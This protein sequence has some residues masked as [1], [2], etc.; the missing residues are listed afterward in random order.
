MPRPR[1]V[2]VC[3]QCGSESP[4]WLGRC[5]EWN[6]YVESLVKPAPASRSGL[7]APVQELARLSSESLPRLVLP[8]IEFNRV[9]G[10]GVVPGSLV[11][12]GGDPG[13]G[14]STLL[15]QAAGAVASGDGTVLYVSGEESVHQIKLRADRLGLRG[16][17]LFL[18]PETELE[19]IIERGTELS[20][21]L[22]VV[23]SI[24]TV[25]QSGLGSAAGSIAQVR[26]CTSRLMQ[27]AKTTDTPIFLVGHV[28]KDGAIAGPH[29]LEHIVDVVLYLEGERF[30]A[31][32]LLRSVK[33]R[34]GST[35]E[36]GVF[37]MRDQGLVE[38]SNPS[39]AWLSQRSEGAIGSAI[40]PTLEGTRPLLVEIQALTSP[41]VFGLPRRNANGVDYNRMLM[42][43]AVLTKRSRLALGNQDII[44]NVVG[45]L[46]VNEPAAGLGIALAVASSLRNAGV[47]AD[48]VALGEIGLSGELRSVSQLDKRLAEAAKLGFGACLMP[49]FPSGQKPPSGI[50]IVTASSV[51][52]A[53]KLGLEPGETQEP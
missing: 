47:R 33:N 4:K 32:R 8:I 15:L 17:G 11:L 16:E 53:L 40:V 35:N 24:Q 1:S 26:E 21:R 3:Q 49:P 22:V 39:R 23:D 27:W 12:I 19:S 28:T 5:P 10:G 20:P 42:I 44:T 38:V 31:Y 36:I 46:R 30:S 52:R 14:K 43:T 45:G 51:S 50:E 25:Y 7:G 41:T 6:T 2:F 29:T 34:F 18:L 37:E 13:I 48:L 9:L